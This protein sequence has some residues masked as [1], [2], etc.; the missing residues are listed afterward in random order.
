MG[1]WDDGLER[2]QDQWMKLNCCLTSRR[3]CGPVWLLGD[4][5]S[6]DAVRGEGYDAVTACGWVDTYQLAQEKGEGF[7]VPGTIDGWE[8]R[9]DS[10]KRLDYIW[11]SRKT[12]IRSSRRIFDGQNGP[13]VSDHFGVIVETME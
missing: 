6:P 10:Q 3:M 11:C 7:T 12:P 4:F 5:N 2:F 8:N 13:I 9:S 1:W